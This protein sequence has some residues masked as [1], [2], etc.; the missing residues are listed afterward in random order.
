MKSWCIFVTMFYFVIFADCFCN[1]VLFCGRFVVIQHVVQVLDIG[2]LCS[3]SHT[4]HTAAECI[5]NHLHGPL[6]V[7]CDFIPGFY[8]CSMHIKWHEYC[9][10]ILSSYAGFVF[11]GWCCHFSIS[12]KCALIFLVLFKILLIKRHLVTRLGLWYLIILV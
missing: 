7:F 3:V 9:E 5:Q 1:C 2:L 4:C 10:I 11:R 6:L 12:T 8:F